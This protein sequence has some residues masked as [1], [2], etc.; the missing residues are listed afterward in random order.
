MF[1][2]LDFG[3]RNLTVLISLAGGLIAQIVLHDHIDILLR[4]L[5]RVGYNHRHLMLAVHINA[6]GQFNRNVAGLANGYL[7]TL[8]RTSGVSVNHLDRQRPSVTI[9]ILITLRNL[10]ILVGLSV[11][12]GNRNLTGLAG[13]ICCIVIILSVTAIRIP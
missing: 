7:R 4:H 1:R 12:N 5:L 11:F 13:L 8:N 6:L 2:F 9:C 10:A 3:N